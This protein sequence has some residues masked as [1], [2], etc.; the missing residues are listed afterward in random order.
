M[1]TV[2]RTVAALGA[3]AALS[4]GCA[5]SINDIPLPGGAEL[6]A[7]PIHVTMEFGDVL[8]LVRQG[9]VKVNGLP[10]GRIEQVGLAADGWTAQIEV[11]LRGDVEL[12]ANAVASIQQTNLL[13]EKFVEL[14]APE[15]APPTGRL[16]DG[17]HLGLDRTR[18]ATDIEQV[19]GALSLLLNGGGLNQL[20]DIITELEKATGGREP[21]LRASLE[22]AGQLMDS[23]NTQR[24]NIVRAIDGVDVL[25]ERA[26]E[27]TP[28]IQAVL[29][30]LPAG[31][32]VLEEQRPQF[33]EML[34][35]LDQLG[36]VG[37]DVLGRSREDLIADLRALRPVLQELAK[38]TPEFVNVAAIVPTFPFPDASV[39]STIGGASNVFL[40]ID[41]QIADTLQNL[42]VGQGDPQE[43]QPRHT[44]G[45]YN[46]DPANPWTGGN[47]PDERTT[48]VL[49]LLP[50]P[51][52][53]QRSTTPR[54][55]PGLGPFS[56][57]V[58]V[59]EQPQGGA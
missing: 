8:D 19:L 7:D 30:E 45:P 27:Q 47:G 6:G 55:A 42:G 58:E 54:E 1:N 43:L 40:S 12:P 17:A 37:S 24:D 39:D 34:V 4:A 52:V 23:L 46:V 35:K 21:E 25:A 26:R 22:S 49:P 3:C 32:R 15:D 41:G 36:T 10:A 50:E 57:L 48:L 31:V 16:Q 13:G 28:Q 51:L 14:S 33:T 11:A 53:M 9:T 5:T 18:T 44:S 20:Q 38:V 56:P 2:L 59:A 29:D